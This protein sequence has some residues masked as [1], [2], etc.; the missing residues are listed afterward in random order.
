MSALNPQRY[1][2]VLGLGFVRDYAERPMLTIGQDVWT[3][4]QL[5]RMGVLQARACSILSTIAKRRK[6]ASLAELYE[7]TSPYSFADYP[8]G[9]ATLYVLFAAF[10]DRGLDPDAW[11]KAGKD[12]ALVSFLTLKARELKARARERED[13][14]RRSRAGKRRQ[15]EGQVSK[16]LAAHP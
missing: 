6:V 4:A 12:A 13:S 9:V 16:F 11:Y 14:K 15:H 2:K 1:V 5:A 10:L 8:A 7:T 3:R